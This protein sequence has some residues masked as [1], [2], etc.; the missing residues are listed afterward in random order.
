M[1]VGFLLDTNVLG[2]VRRARRG[3]QKVIER[4][5]SI[6]RNLQFISV[7]TL[8]EV[9]LGVL[10]KELKDPAQGSHLRVWLDS[11]VRPNF[12]GRILPV[13]E[14]VAL[15]CAGLHVPDQ[16]PQH[17]ALL[18]ATALV[19]NLTVVTRNVGDFVRMNVPLFNPWDDP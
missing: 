9:A 6:P 12:S 4:V 17:D 19:Y 18:A 2:E 15:Y 7:I 8:L 11:V 5:E 14:T 16:R 13:T 10:A 1:T 3:N